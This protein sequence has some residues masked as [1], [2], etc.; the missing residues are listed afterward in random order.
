[1]KSKF[2][3]LAAIFVAALFSFGSCSGAD[4]PYLPPNPDII[5]ALKNLYP[6]VENIEWSQKGVYYVAD[7]WVKGTELDV[8]F[9][10]DA[11]WVMT[12]QE[13]FRE[14][15]PAAVETAYA[16]SNYADWVIDNLTLL[17]FPVKSEE[18]VFEVQG[19]TQERALFYS[20][21]GDL[22]KEKDITNA[23]FTKWPDVIGN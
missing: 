11:N 6:S 12:E 9:D 21:E 1:M 16:T 14:Q 15:L 5:T 13:I 19:G 3:I 10:A 18:Y 20:A 7:C 23:D 2:S 17:T 8:W 4:D 22:L